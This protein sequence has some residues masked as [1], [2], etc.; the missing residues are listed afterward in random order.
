MENFSHLNLL[1]PYR[2]FEMYKKSFRKNLK[3]IFHDKD[4]HFYLH[5]KNLHLKKNQLKNLIELRWANSQF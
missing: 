1:D 5:P 2:N 3:S 4:S